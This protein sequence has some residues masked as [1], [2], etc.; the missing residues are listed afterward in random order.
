MN[1][2]LYFLSEI[3]TKRDDT[4][5]DFISCIH[6]FVGLAQGGSI[7]AATHAVEVPTKSRGGRRRNT[8]GSDSFILRCGSFDGEPNPNCFSYSGLMGQRSSQLYFYLF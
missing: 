6:G 1:V 4:I 5:V 8:D 7:G 3:S 2:S